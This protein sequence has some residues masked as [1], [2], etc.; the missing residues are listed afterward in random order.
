MALSMLLWLKKV[1][2]QSIAD[3]I[4]EGLSIAFKLEVQLPS[5]KMQTQLLHP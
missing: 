1:A 3:I 4:N 2:S 5:G